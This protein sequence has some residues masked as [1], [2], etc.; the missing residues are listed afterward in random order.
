MTGAVNQEG[1]ML[2]D[3]DARDAGN[4]ESPE[5]ALPSAPE[6]TQQR[7]QSETDE[8]GDGLHMSILPADE[9]VFLKIGHVVVGLIGIELKQEPAD[10]G[11][12]KSFRDAVGIIVMIDVFM[13]AAMFACPHQD[14]VFEGGR[15]ED[16]DEK[17][18]WPACLE[19][20][21]REQTVI[22]QGDAKSA[23]DQHGEEKRDLK[24]VETE[25]VKIEWDAR[26]GENKC[27]D[28]ERAGEPVDMGVKKSFRDA[29]GIIVMIDVFMVA[30]M[31]ARPHQ[32]DDP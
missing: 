11:V 28:E 8:N 14:G 30:A 20:P 27:A 15:A 17:A 10:M 6:K 23:R 24:P 26:Q 32:D 9:A 2:Q 12:K 31:F 7:G 18:Q 19:G 21:M 29:V 4:E 25:V 5:R 3:N 22:T 16:E 1:A 13:V